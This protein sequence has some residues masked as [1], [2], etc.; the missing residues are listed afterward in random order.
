MRSTLRAGSTRTYGRNRSIPIPVWNG[1]LEHRDRI[2][3][4]I[5]EFFWCLDKITKEA[6]GIGWIFSGAPVKIS[7][8]ATDLHEDEKTARLHLA[9]LEKRGYIQR[10]RTPYGFI[11]R[12]AKSLKFGI[13]HG[14]VSGENAQSGPRRDRQKRPIYT[15]KKPDLSGQYA[16]N[17]V[18]ATTDAAIDAAVGPLAVCELW[19]MIGISARKM[20][21]AFRELCERL[22]PTRNGQPLFAFM[23]TCM[24]AWA[25]MGEQRYPPDFAKAKARL[26]A[27]EKEKTP[28]GGKPKLAFLPPLPP[29]P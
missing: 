10:T 9:M 25:A 26:V 2:G 14:R 21:P 6:D 3:R 4:A 7:T 11:I 17:K 8:I 15:A 22:Y 20:P 28:P 12:V 24:D 5:W 19:N 18:D 27:L 23:G 29:I 16:R 13:W 1:I